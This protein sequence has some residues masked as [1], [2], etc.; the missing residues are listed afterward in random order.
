MLRLIHERIPLREWLGHLT[1]FN[2]NVQIRN[3]SARTLLITMVLESRA[4]SSCFA[5]DDAVVV[6]PHTLESIPPQPLHNGV[7]GASARATITFSKGG[8]ANGSAACLLLRPGE[9]LRVV[10]G[11]ADD[12]MF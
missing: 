9:C 2:S 8:G 5:R 3:E 4:A 11:A 7:D 12:A 10:A 1:L 6:P